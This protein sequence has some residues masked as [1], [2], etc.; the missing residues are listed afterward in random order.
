VL[1][2]GRSGNSPGGAGAKAPGGQTN[3]DLKVEFK[4]NAKHK[5]AAQHKFLMT[6]QQP[7]VKLKWYPQ[8]A[9]GVIEHV[10]ILLDVRDEP[11]PESHQHRF[12]VSADDEG[13]FMVPGHM[14]RPNAP[15]FIA[16][17]M[18]SAAESGYD[19]LGYELEALTGT[20]DSAGAPI[21]NC[22]RWVNGNG[23]AFIGIWRDGKPHTGKGAW[24]TLM[25][26]T[27]EAT[28]AVMQGDWRGG[29]GSGV[30]TTGPDAGRVGLDPSRD[31]AKEK[32]PWEVERDDDT[33]HKD[34]EI[35][36]F[37]GDWD[38]QNMPTSGKGE[39]MSQS[40]H[41]YNGVWKDYQGT[42]TVKASKR[43]GKKATDFDDHVELPTFTGDWLE[44]N[45]WDGQGIWYDV[46][47][48]AFTGTIKEGK[49]FTG[50]GKWQ[51]YETLDDGEQRALELEEGYW[52][53]GLKLAEAFI[54]K[55]ERSTVKANRAV[56]HFFD[57]TSQ[58]GPLI[59]T[60]T[61][62]QTT[63]SFKNLDLLV[64][65]VGVPDMS[66]FQYRQECSIE[67]GGTIEIEDECFH[68]AR[69]YVKVIVTGTHGNT[70]SSAMYD[71][72]QYTIDFRTGSWKPTKRAVK[73][74]FGRN[75]WEIPDN[76]EGTW[77]APDGITFRGVF[78]HGMPMNGIGTWKSECE[79]VHE[80]T[81]E[82]GKGSGKIM[83]PKEELYEGD[84]LDGWP[85]HGKGT[86]TGDDGNT[87]MPDEGEWRA[88]AGEGSIVNKNG[89]TFWGSW[90]GREPIEGRGKWLNKRGQVFEGN[91]SEG[92]GMGMIS[93]DDGEIVFEGEW[94]GETPFKGKGSWRDTD[95]NVYEG[96]W[97]N[98][99][100]YGKDLSQ[101]NKLSIGNDLS[102]MVIGA[103]DDGDESTASGPAQSALSKTSSAG[104]DTP[105]EHR[106]KP[107]LTAG[108]KPKAGHRLVTGRRFE[109]EWRDG[110]P[111]TGLGMFRG[112]MGHVFDGTWKKGRPFEGKGAWMSEEGWV[113]DG[114]IRSG[115]VVQA[116]GKWRCTLPIA[117]TD[118]TEDNF[119]G[120]VFE[121]EY[122]DGVPFSG[123]GEWWDGHNHIYSGEWASLEGAG[124]IDMLDI[125]AVTSS[126]EYIGKWRGGLPLSGEGIWVDL[127]GYTF[128]GSWNNASPYT[129]QGEWNYADNVYNGRWEEGKG[130]GR[131]TGASGSRYKGT[132]RGWR[133]WIGQGEFVDPEEHRYTGDYK[134]GAPWNG[135]GNWK[136]VDGHVYR[137]DLRN[138]EPWNGEGSFK[139][140]RRN[141]VYE[142]KWRESNGQGNI[143]GEGE[144]VYHGTWRKG[145]PY[146]GKGSWRSIHMKAFSGE[147]E[148]SEGAGTIVGL[149]KGE[150]YE[151]AWID[152]DGAPVT[153]AGR[154]FSEEGFLNMYEGEWKDTRGTGRIT[155]P[156]GQIYKG[157]WWNLAPYKGKGVFRGPD[158]FD[159]QG[160]WKNGTR[161]WRGRKW[162]DS[163]SLQPDF[164]IRR[165]RFLAGR[166]SAEVR[167]REA[168]EMA[169][170]FAKGETK[171]SKDQST[172]AA[173][174]RDAQ[175]GVESVGQPLVIAD[176]PDDGN[177]LALE[178]KTGEDETDTD[179]DADTTR[180]LEALQLALDCGAL[181]KKDF[182]RAKAR[183][184]GKGELEVDPGAGEQSDEESRELEKVRSAS[185]RSRRTANPWAEDMEY[186]PPSAEPSPKEQADTSPKKR[187]EKKKK[188]APIIESPEDSPRSAVSN[189]SSAPSPVASSDEELNA[190]E[191]PSTIRAADAPQ[192]NITFDESSL[193]TSSRR[194]KLDSMDGGSPKAS[195]PKS[196]DSTPK[197]ITRTGS[198]SPKASSPKASSPGPRERGQGHRWGEPIPRNGNQS[199]QR[200]S[201]EAQA[202]YDELQWELEA[203]SW[204]A[205]NKAAGTTSAESPDAAGADPGASPEAERGAS[206]DRPNSVQLRYL[207]RQSTPHEGV[208]PPVSAQAKTKR[209]GSRS[210][211]PPE[212]E[213]EPEPGLLPADVFAVEGR[214]TRGSSAPA[215]KLPSEDDLFAVEGIKKKKKKRGA[216][217]P[218]S[219]LPAAAID[220]FA[221][222]GRPQRRVPEVVQRGVSPSLVNK[223]KSLPRDPQLG[224]TTSLYSSAAEFTLVVTCEDEGLVRGAHKL[225]LRAHSLTAVLS[226]IKAQLGL[227]KEEA[228]ANLGLYVMDP[229]F[230]EYIVL[231]SI[232]DLPTRAKVRLVYRPPSRQG[233]AAS[234]RGGVDPEEEKRRQEEEE[235]AEQKA[236]Q[237][238]LLEARKATE[239]SQLRGTKKK[240]KKQPKTST[241]LAELRAVRT[242][243]LESDPG[244]AMSLGSQNQEQRQVL[245]ES[246]HGALHAIETV[247]DSNT[248]QIKERNMLRKLQGR[249]KM[250]GVRAMVLAEEEERAL[251]DGGRSSS[252]EPLPVIDP[253]AQPR[254]EG[255]WEDNQPF[256]GKGRWLSPDGHLYAGTW[257]QGRPQDGDG[258]WADSRGCVFDGKW[259]AGVPYHGEGEFSNEKGYVW[260]GRWKLGVGFGSITFVHKDEELSRFD[261][262]WTAGD[263]PPHTGV[264]NWVDARVGSGSGSGPGSTPD[265]LSHVEGK[266]PKLPSLEETLDLSRRCEGEWRNGE[267]VNGSG[268]WRSPLTMWQFDGEWKDG[269]GWGTYKKPGA[270]TR[271]VPG[272]WAG[273]MPLHH[274]GKQ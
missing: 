204:M 76:N 108:I 24:S 133:P 12:E 42:G 161:T 143:Y 182:E 85:T 189:S 237:L 158:G 117:Y 194:T 186:C 168:T 195:S 64:S 98:G 13:E 192:L 32:R 269:E 145:V 9:T 39:F 118:G 240:K 105:T 152:G 87:Y 263:G 127:D 5:K 90:E 15:L 215:S 166:Q 154:W 59:I 207:R 27:G 122:K 151:G 162:Q 184:T 34:L 45:P 22:G 246:E 86:F 20:W 71:F 220:L 209:R 230:D 170:D 78:V 3:V 36:R 109:G 10:E 28:L 214:R 38:E 128:T 156:D 80:G 75:K 185:M 225:S 252:V 112:Q 138:G 167:A 205:Q 125:S 81:W 150:T 46:N 55:V 47:D 267:L 26:G 250:A 25:R 140:T 227:A 243:L 226:E 83:G 178:L 99:I 260:S 203:K 146:T 254:F 135:T 199:V 160:A 261:G 116:T 183:I 91:W 208:L 111:W 62:V 16:V 233:S 4:G 97:R 48:N 212:P 206:S 7:P 40:R 103:D 130:A 19:V 96:D 274:D 217:P 211:P 266:K 173:L 18:Y 65:T 228:A 216:T 120:R 238:E 1:S 242:R 136:S 171:K 255:E 218:V 177:S 132:W 248:Q 72:L 259:K 106:K 14:A 67:K 165:S 43:A 77:V 89:A 193:V 100:L 174:L 247:Q 31:S 41:V 17:N 253:R 57:V 231:K 44:E 262:K 6:C 235:L 119:D 148:D 58:Q 54:E 68:P 144:E 49:A 126:G 82:N 23:H 73:D 268:Q 176:K 104:A 107:V 234:S 197:A 265:P 264:G 56:E 70:A 155:G 115:R 198:M 52:W 202:R 213:P 163:E 200:R 88:G 123:K 271:T 61:P 190:I 232:E 210:D 169:S 101:L 159:F 30:L 35:F 137:G 229:E 272:R 239:K 93:S 33:E 142:G 124:T 256:Q 102:K 221:I 273:G 181:S 92:E 196:P 79:N 191:P 21:D 69:F 175:P 50:K 222:E 157:E 147:W 180:K 244:M 84:W 241:S 188:P 114:E 53:K 223:T 172:V 66:S 63:G 74:E 60:L 94:R 95:G 270:D 139:D 245:A 236:I 153:G 201:A 121:G 134:D 219:T 179:A 51:L 110:K 249:K 141:C 29:S 37:T 8:T 131:I 224:P 258:A 164:K 11:T 129:G 113:I 187:K 257:Q 251:L 2:V 149:K